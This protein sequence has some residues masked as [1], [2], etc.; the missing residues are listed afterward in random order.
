MIKWKWFELK[1]VNWVLEV[2][3]WIKCITNGQLVIKSVGLITIEG[4]LG[5]AIALAAIA[6]E[7][8]QF[9]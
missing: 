4:K 5:N 7:L 6:I 2:K 9:N 8:N 1:N 3:S